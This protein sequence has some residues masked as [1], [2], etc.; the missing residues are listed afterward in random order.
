VSTGVICVPEKA[1]PDAAT[2]NPIT[3]GFGITVI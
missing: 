3:R 2:V 1:K